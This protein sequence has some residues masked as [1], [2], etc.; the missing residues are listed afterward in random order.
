[1]SQVDDTKILHGHRVVIIGGSSGIG[2][3]IALRSIRA[4]AEVI[5]AA[6]RVDRL[7]DIIDEAGGGQIAEVDLRV[8]ESCSNLV[9][10]VRADLETVDLLFI[11]AG[12]APLRGFR[13]TSEEDWLRAFSTN[14]IGIHR[15]IAGCLDLLSPRA[16]VAVVSTEA[17]DSPRSHLGA[18]GASKAALEHSMAQWREEYPWLR[19]TTISL[20]ATVPTEFGH[21]FD[22]G[23]ITN[24]I[25]KW[26][27]TGRSHAAFMD[28]DE[29]CDFLVHTLGSLV[30]APSVGLP[31]ISLRSPAPLSTDPNHVLE[32]AASNRPS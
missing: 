18:Y 20:G 19:F 26:A 21:G 15:I 16:V 2:R 28:T 12:V 32:T 31:L 22:P 10:Q 3:G 9:A 30:L 6:R 24:A 1:M 17:V 8:G 11:S 23:E 7:K 27:E 14:V 29:V 5:V 13:L 4:G 25:G